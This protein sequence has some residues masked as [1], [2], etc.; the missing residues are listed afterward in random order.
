M[1]GLNEDEVCDFVA[2][3]KEKVN[4]DGLFEITCQTVSW[5]LLAFY[6]R[7]YFH[8]TQFSKQGN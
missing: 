4:K 2:L 8:H 7:L 5:F 3:T 1:R 6:N